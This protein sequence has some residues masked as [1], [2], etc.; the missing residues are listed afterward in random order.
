MNHVDIVVFDFETGGLDPKFHEA[1]SVAGKAYNCRS[2]EPYPIEKGGE[3]YA[4]MKPLHFD[5]LQDEALKINRITREELEKAPDQAVVWNQFIEWV[6]RFNPKGTQFMAPIA[7]GKNIRSFDLLFAEQLNLLHGPKKEKTVLFSRRT[8]LDLEDFMFHWFENE[9]EPEK[10]NMD[11]LRP[12]FGLT[13]DGAH[14][15][16]IDARQT[17]VL[18]MKFLKLCRYLQK[19]QVIKFKGSLKGAA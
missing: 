17:G 15:A 16:L 3:F 2:L 7:A 14:N 6:N 4:V 13:L 10:F 8:Q 11:T 5:R 18:I 1:I 19:K 12:W 9:R